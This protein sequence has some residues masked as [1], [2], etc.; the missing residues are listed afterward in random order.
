MTNLRKIITII[1]LIVIL[2]VFGWLIIQ[3]VKMGINYW[4]ESK[5]EKEEVSLTVKD[6][7]KEE[8]AKDNDM[9]GLTNEEEK[10]LGTNLTKA[11]S[12]ND[13][14][15]DYHEVKIYGT[16]PLLKDTDGDGHEDKK[17]VVDGFN[18]NGEGK[19]QL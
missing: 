19:L 3:A 11:D 4:Q 1:V 8:Y 10:L 17:E 6:V 5:G 14:L 13:G 2:L 16:N 15:F 7:Y 9:D 12:D 18:P